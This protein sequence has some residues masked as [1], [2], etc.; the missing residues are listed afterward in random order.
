MGK[1]PVEKVSSVEALRDT[2]YAQRNSVYVPGKRGGTFDYTETDPYG[3]GDDNGIVFQNKRGNYWVRRFS[4][5]LNVKWWG[6]K[7]D[8]FTDD[9]EALESATNFAYQT[10][11]TLFLPKGDYFIGSTLEIENPIRIEGEGPARPRW[12]VPTNE[13]PTKIVVDDSLFIGV[14]IRSTSNTGSG[15][16][17]LEGLQ[18]T[19]LSVEPET[20][21]NPNIGIQIDGSDRGVGAQQVQDFIFRNV[22]VRDFQDHNLLVKGNV[23]DAR[24]NECGFY[25]SGLASTKFESA[26]SNGINDPEQI[27]FTNCGLQSVDGELCIE[28]DN[29][30]FVI[31]GGFFAGK[32]GGV[33]L[34]DKSYLAGSIFETASTSGVGV[35]IQGSD[36]VCNPRKVVGYANSF[37]IQNSRYRINCPYIKGPSN[38]GFFVTSG[39]S[40]T[41]VVKQPVFIDSNN[42]SSGLIQNDR[43]T[44]DGEPDFFVDPISK[45][46]DSGTR[47]P[48]EAR[49]LG[50]SYFDNSLSTPRAIWWDGSQW[51]DGSGNPV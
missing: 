13:R 28:Q 48:P 40:R 5:K 9:I 36:I 38:S 7:G 33:Q 24:F 44:T 10:K 49:T 11:K 30:S 31:I 8:G 41:G 32:G 12:N 27:Y 29:T 21:K 2:S 47:P 25:R 22:N 42:A 39:G 18:I 19:N 17:K 51:V 23:F 34:G 1:H 46:G 26:T 4:G 16:D 14:V 37:Y 3:N 35:Y 50:V 45:S 15:Y 20:S 6:A 43:L